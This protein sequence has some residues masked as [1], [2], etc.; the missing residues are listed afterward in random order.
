MKPVLISGLVCGTIC[1]VLMFGTMFALPASAHE[2]GVPHN[3]PGVSASTTATTTAVTATTTVGATTTPKT[4]LGSTTIAGLLAQLAKLT[5][6]FNSLKAQMLG[7]Q[8]EIKEL[9]GD[10]KEGMTGSDV[11]TVQE[12]LASDASIYPQGL[13]TGFFGPMTK[14][15][16]KRFQAKNGL[17]VTGEINVETRAALDSLLEQRRGDGKY[18]DG[19]RF[20]TSTKQ[21]FEERLK[22]RCDT[23]V[24]ATSTAAHPCVQVKEKY[25]FWH[26]MKDEM[27][28][29]LKDMKDMMRD[30]MKDMKGKKEHGTSSK[31]MHDDAETDDDN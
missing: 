11:K 24:N 26:D 9:R 12:L 31:M 27:K 6:L 8:T 3:E 17:E 2:T 21:K 15:A 28:G 19:L 4:P 10:I 16:L 30:Q 29:G 25:N 23:F 22:K 18:P 5:E 14:E 1:T 20:S 7:V 13:A